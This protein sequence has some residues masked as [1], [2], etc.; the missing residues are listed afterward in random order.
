M[1]FKDLK[2]LA[3]KE[4]RAY[5]ILTIWLLLGYSFLQFDPNNLIGVN[6]LFFLLSTCLLYFIFNLLIKNKIDQ[7]PLLYLLL[8]LFLAFP[9]NILIIN[10]GLLVIVILFVIAIVYWKGVLGL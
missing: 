7:H 5:L 10:Y 4:K 8:C 3:H 9:L 1:G 6:L 2:I